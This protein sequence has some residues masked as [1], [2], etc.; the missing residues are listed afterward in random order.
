[1]TEVPIV[2][3]TNSVSVGGYVHTVELLL[4]RG[5]QGMR[6]SRMF[7]GD[8]PPTGLPPSHSY[9][10]GVTEF[11][12]GDMFF[13]RSGL[14]QGDLWEY[15]SQPG[16]NDWVLILPRSYPPVYAGNGSPEGV[17][18]ANQGT[19]YI[20]QNHATLVYLKWRKLSGSGNTG[21]YPDF[22][23]RWIS[24]TPGLT[25]STTSP[26]NWTGTGFYSQ[27]GKTVFVKGQIV[28]GASMTAGSG[29]YRLSLPVNAS[30]SIANVIADGSVSLV[31]ASPSV[32]HTGMIVYIPASTYVQL[33]SGLSAAPSV[34]SNTVPWTWAANDSIR[35]AFTYETV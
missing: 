35:F 1:M 28:A 29:T 26:T 2:V 19:E 4:D 24:Y 6:G 10:G 21:W 15:R 25:A 30:T 23:G 34:V 18:T 11:V 16:G 12:L 33:K 3:S 32:E 27:T 22:E 20:Q 9:F 5:S 8:L 14:Y 31:D 7:S 13:V 17:V